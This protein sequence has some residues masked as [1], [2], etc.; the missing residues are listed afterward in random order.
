MRNPASGLGRE[1]IELFYELGLLSID[2][3]FVRHL[4]VGTTGTTGISGVDRY[5]RSSA[6]MRS[7]F[8]WHFLA[9]SCQRSVLASAI[10]LFTSVRL[11]FWPKSVCAKE[12]T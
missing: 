12:L 4:P 6:M 9:R 11:G 3:Q 5:D 10:E 7:Q 2:T 1:H 8:I